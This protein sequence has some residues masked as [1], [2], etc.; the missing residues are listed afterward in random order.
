MSVVEIPRRPYSHHQPYEASAGSMS[1]K[2]SSSSSRGVL[3][4][5]NPN[6]VVD[7]TPKGSFAS[8]TEECNSKEMAAL[9]RMSNL[10]SSNNENNKGLANS[11]LQNS[12]GGG[13]SSGHFRRQ[14]SNS[15]RETDATGTI[16]DKS[17]A[18][19]S[20]HTHSSSVPRPAVGARSA[21]T[22]IIPDTTAM[23]GDSVLIEEKRRKVNG[24]GYTLHRYLRGR[25][26]GKGGFAKVYLCT[27]LDTNKA[28][29]IKIVP[30]ANLVKTRAR[31]KVRSEMHVEKSPC[32]LV[33]RRL[34]HL[35]QF[36]QCPYSC[37]LKSKS[38]ER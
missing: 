19:H 33:I 15:E 29:A 16:R 10:E 21:S 1:S 4:A 23:D 24:E 5:R 28:Y 13:S 31:Q 12:Y 8:S 2:Q 34:S 9:N 3:Q 22:P 6:V 30:K 32:C 7:V 18:G 36:L 26:L 25:L 17:A 35:I 38:T 20:A 11:N 14:S 27:A 37:K